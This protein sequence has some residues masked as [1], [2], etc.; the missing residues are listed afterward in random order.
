MQ[1]H[2]KVE[3]TLKD[4]EVNHQ[5][6]SIELRKAKSEVEYLKEFETKYQVFSDIFVEENI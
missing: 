3:E 4:I 2:E 6:S 5:D 1:K